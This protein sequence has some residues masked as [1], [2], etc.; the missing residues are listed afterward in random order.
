MRKIVVPAGF[1]VAVLIIARAWGRLAGILGVSIA[2]LLFAMFL[3][4]PVGSWIV[5]DDSARNNLGWM[6]LGEMAL[7]YFAGRAGPHTVPR[8]D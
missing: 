4:N 1:L 5:S 2:A 8:R 3:L 6:M 7:S